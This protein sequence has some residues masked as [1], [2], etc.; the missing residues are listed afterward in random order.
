MTEP[1][2]TSDIIEDFTLIEKDEAAG[3]DRPAPA[4]SS[5]PELGGAKADAPN[6][7]KKTAKL[8]IE[9]VD[10][11]IEDTEET[12]DD[13]DDFN[14]DLLADYPDDSE[15]HSPQYIPRLHNHFCRNLNLFTLVSRLARL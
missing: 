12:D 3:Y 10:S 14:T 5:E 15:V 7:E 13:K 9:Q 6:A 11:D 2:T 4:A 1:S 8:V